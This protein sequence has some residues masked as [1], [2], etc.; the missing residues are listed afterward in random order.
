MT[1]GG[2]SGGVEGAL[3]QQGGQYVTLMLAEQVYCV[4]VSS[5][6]DIMRKQRISRIPSLRRGSPASSTCAAGS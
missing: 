6:R 4:A 1:A 3:A 2:A 5:V